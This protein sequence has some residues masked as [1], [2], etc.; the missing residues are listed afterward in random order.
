MRSAYYDERT[1]SIVSLDPEQRPGG[2][3][4]SRVSVLPPHR[5]QG[6]ATRLMQE[7]LAAA[8]AEGA[9]LYLEPIPTAGEDGPNRDQLIRWYEGFGFRPYRPELGFA[10]IR[11]PQAHA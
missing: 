11:R 7:V 3:T 9:V 4:I 10:W 1:R 6:I 5:R 2:W 8:D